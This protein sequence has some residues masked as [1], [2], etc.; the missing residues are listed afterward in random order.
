MNIKILLFIVS[1]LTST[2]IYTAEKPK[3]ET[4]SLQQLACHFLSTKS[5]IEKQ[6]TKEVALIAKFRFRDGFNDKINVRPSPLKVFLHQNPDI[7]S[8]FEKDLI[9]L[10][11]SIQDLLDVGTPITIENGYWGPSLVLPYFSL[12]SLDGFE[13][14]TNF[15]TVEFLYFP[16][17]SIKR[18]D[19]TIL[20]KCPRLKSFSL[21]NNGLRQIEPGTFKDLPFL[22]YICLWGNCFNEID[23]DD[24]EL[25]SLC[26]LYING[27]KNIALKQNSFEKLPNLKR[28]YL[29]DFEQE[30]KGAK[31]LEKIRHLSFKHYAQ[32]DDKTEKFTFKVDD[33]DQLLED[34]KDNE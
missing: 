32:E 2:T 8:L 29:K 9:S 24:F 16:L 1:V 34:N 22:N 5:E 33:I 12:T 13:N 30:D 3:G 15:S 23:L 4:I 21:E 25:P 27:V 19:P 17:N 28:I 10:S 14:I 11:L 18:L 26:D 6:I 31:N 20:K 7:K